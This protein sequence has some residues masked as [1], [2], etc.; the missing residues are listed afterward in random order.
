MEDYNKNKRIIIKVEDMKKIYNPLKKAGFTIPK[1]SQIIGVD[2]RGSLY[3]GNSISVENFINLL[4]LYRKYSRKKIP[5]K[6]VLD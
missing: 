3:R 2:F 5:Y 4:K 1:I 6:I